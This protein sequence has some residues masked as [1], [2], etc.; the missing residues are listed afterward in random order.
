MAVHI[1][2]IDKKSVDELKKILKM[3]RSE[4]AKT[5]N[6]DRKGDITRQMQS[7]MDKIKKAGG[8]KAIAKAAKASP[9]EA[10]VAAPPVKKAKKKAPAKK[11]VKKKVKKK[12]P[13]KKVMKKAAVKK[14]PAKKVMKK[15]VAKK[16]P[17]KSASK[18]AR[19]QAIAD[20]LKKRSAPKAVAPKEAQQMLNGTAKRKMAYDAKVASK[21]PA[22]KGVVRKASKKAGKLAGKAA[23]VA[24]TASTV[25]G[26]ATLKGDTGPR[27]A[28]V[29]KRAEAKAKRDYAAL[30]AKRK[31][32]PEAQAPK[33]PPA[34]P[35]KS[36]PYRSQ[37]TA[38]IQVSEQA[39]RMKAK[40]KRISKE[41]S[42]AKAYAKESKG[43]LY[44]ALKDERKATGDV[45]PKRRTRRAAP[46]SK[47]YKTPPRLKRQMKKTLS[48]PVDK[49]DPRRFKAVRDKE[50][51]QQTLTRLNQTM[52]STLTK[53]G[54]GTRVRHILS[55]TP[56]AQRQAK[57]LYLYRQ[58]RKK[59]GMGQ[60]G[61]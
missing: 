30:K 31:K 43:K 15:V 16:A 38:D 48:R 1:G 3:L 47:T 9:K 55:K 4:Y 49:S 2:S 7:V 26:L 17:V 51:K 58:G 60:V 28:A 57:L 13:A 61:K 41:R 6:Y 10:D 45:R 36:K 44:K 22:K 23:R 42:D 11:V 56:Q 29:Q 40:G 34:K 14:A 5:K 35:Y 18:Q 37:G 39:K 27:T 54:Y 12:A 20:K 21:T 52:A 19:L 50:T 59:R 24:G 46:K 32:R 33:T 8:K 25:A 53:W